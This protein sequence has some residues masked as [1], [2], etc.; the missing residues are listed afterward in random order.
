MPGGKYLLIGKAGTRSIYDNLRYFTFV[1][2]PK[3]E[4]RTLHNE[5]LT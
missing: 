2:L 5:P 4:A 3:R 1:L